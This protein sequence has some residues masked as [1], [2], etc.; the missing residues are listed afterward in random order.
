MCCSTSTAAGVRTTG[1]RATTVPRRSGPNFGEI[2]EPE[3][4]RPYTAVRSNRTSWYTSPTRR[5][6]CSVKAW[7]VCSLLSL[8]AAGTPGREHAM[9][10]F[11]AF[12]LAAVLAAGDAPGDPAAV[13]A[14]MREALREAAPLPS[15]RPVLPEGALPAAQ[16]TDARRTM[17]RDAERMA[18][19]HAKKGASQARHDARGEGTRR[20]NADET[21]HGD[22]EGGDP[23]CDPAEMMRSRGTMPGGD[24]TMPA[25]DPRH[26][27]M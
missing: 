1:G 15:A 24:H 6:A 3:R 4:L 11:H 19:E 17:K 23:S 13:R 22:R 8:P 25:P 14:A 16:M 9:P 20:G 2:H 5:R 27:G 18:I 26:R 7:V 21:M 12:V 10:A